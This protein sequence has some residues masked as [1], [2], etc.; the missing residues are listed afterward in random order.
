[1]VS[2]R[3]DWSPCHSQ[4]LG[5]TIFAGDFRAGELRDMVF[6]EVG[7]TVERDLGAFGLGDLVQPA[8]QTV[9]IAINKPSNRFTGKNRCLVG[10][11]FGT[12]CVWPF[13]TFFKL[14]YISHHRNV[15]AKVSGIIGR[16]HR[17]P[18]ERAAKEAGTV[19]TEGR[20]RILSSQLS[21]CG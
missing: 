6:E 13:L 8:L 4:F 12:P 20:R 11:A 3:L 18:P 9:S 7:E 16:V 21:G 15:S 2:L 17:P 19:S 10:Q 5:A 1:M 14:A